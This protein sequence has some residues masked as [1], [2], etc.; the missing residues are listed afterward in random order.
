MNNLRQNRIFHPHLHIN[1]ELT[2][3]YASSAIRTFAI[4]LIAIFEPIYIYLTF[5]R[6]LT[7]AFLYFGLFSLLPC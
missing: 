6:S 5:D 2:E 4:A 1:R 7:R 3:L